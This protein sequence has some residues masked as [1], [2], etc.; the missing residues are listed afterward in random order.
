MAQRLRK[1]NT[2]A[3]GNWM[4]FGRDEYEPGGI[5]GEC[6]QADDT[7][8]LANPGTGCRESE[9]SVPRNNSNNKQRDAIHYPEPAA[10]FSGS[11]SIRK[12]TF[13]TTV[14]APGQLIANQDLE[15][16]VLN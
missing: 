3:L 11:R 5:E 2:P 8:W 15:A 10:S 9:V 6:L 4:I 14:L 13:K 16:D 1:R 7:N 12:S